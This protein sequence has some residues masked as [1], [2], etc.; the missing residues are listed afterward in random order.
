MALPWICPWAD[1]WLLLYIWFVALA[2]QLW[3]RSSL[4]KGPSLTYY[5]PALDPP[6]GGFVIIAIHSVSCSSLPTLQKK[7][8]GEGPLIDLYWLC[9][10]SLA[11]Q[12]WRRSPLEKGPSLIYYGPALDLPLG[13]FVIIAI[14]SVCCSSLPTLRR[15]P[16][17]KGTSLTYYGPAL[18][19]P[20]GGFVIIAIH[21]VCCSSLPTLKN[22]FREGPLRKRTIPKYMW[23]ILEIYCTY[24]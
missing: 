8:F 4:E 11:F 10:G 5:G 21:S 2:F 15:S 19:L 18:D 20:L 3:R 9:P 13:R 24:M 23:H 6:L 7:S 12:L 16:L 17:E 1:L 14:H 22:S